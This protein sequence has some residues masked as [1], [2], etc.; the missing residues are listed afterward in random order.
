[1]HELLDSYSDKWSEAINHFKNEI[2]S[3]RSNRA[4]P[5]LVENILVDYYGT[6]TPLKQI[7]TITVPEPRQILV[8]PWDKNVLKEVE[9]ALQKNDNNFSV[10]ND[11]QS[12]H[13]SLPQ[14]TEETRKETAT[15]LHA[16]MEETR[17]AIRKIREDILKK[18]KQAKE[19]S[20]IS[21]DD[22]FKI[23]KDVQEIVDKNN[24]LVKQLGEEKEKDIMTI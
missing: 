15:V 23:Q 11:G 10:K 14:M 21:E 24:E 4:N 22:F 19:N 3:L 2:K 20:E 9:S 17:I 8:D 16:K 13:I 18:A 7:A 1:M 6:P 5:A 12:L